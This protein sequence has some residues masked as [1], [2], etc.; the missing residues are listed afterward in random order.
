M[1]VLHLTLQDGERHI[2]LTY[3]HSVPEI[4]P[5]NNELTDLSPVW[6]LPGILPFSLIIPLQ[7]IPITIKS[8]VT[9]TTWRSPGEDEYTSS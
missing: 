7:D 3:G 1:P 8:P 2:P 9:M 4:V 5:T 6:M